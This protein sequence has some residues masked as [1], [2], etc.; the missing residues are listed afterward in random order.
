MTC[1]QCTALILITLL[2]SKM[3][4][5]K[6]YTI[7]SASILMGYGFLK[8]LALCAVIMIGGAV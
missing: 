7:I 2:E 5:L 3:T 6:Q 4:E 8:F 1:Q